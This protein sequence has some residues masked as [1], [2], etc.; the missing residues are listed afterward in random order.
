MSDKPGFKPYSEGSI[1][2]G[3]K[4]GL[5]DLVKGVPEALEKGLSSGSG[6]GDQNQKKQNFVGDVV[7]ESENQI[8]PKQPRDVEAEIKQV[9]QAKQERNE[10]EEEFLAQLKAKR[11]EEEKIIEAES[12]DIMP[13]SAPAKGVNPKVATKKKSSPDQL[14]QRE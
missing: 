14:R 11:E 2:S 12:F 7:A 8:K 5:K 9:R 3:V 4:D 1:A 6:S 13:S 10:Q